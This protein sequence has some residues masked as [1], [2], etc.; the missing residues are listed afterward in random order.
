MCALPAHTPLL[1]G[2]CRRCPLLADRRRCCHQATILEL[3]GLYIKFG[4]V[5]SVRPEIVPAAY[6]EQFKKLQ[7]EVPAVDFAGIKQTV[8]RELGA[9]LE[10]CFAEFDERPLGCASIGQ[11]S[12]PVAHMD[13]G[14]G[15]GVRVHVGPGLATDCLGRPP[16]T[17]CVRNAVADDGQPRVCRR[18]ARG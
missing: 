4:Q 12:G 16:C 15:G 7:A 6:R 10:E 17:H 13:G 1:A 2:C 9:P 5:C 18:T 14:G 11:V 3:R 8:E